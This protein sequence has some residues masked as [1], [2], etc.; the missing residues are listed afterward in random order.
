MRTHPLHLLRRAG[1]VF[2][3]SALE[4]A[5]TIEVVLIGT[6][7]MVGLPIVVSIDNVPCSYFAQAAGRGLKLRADVLKGEISRGNRLRSLLLCYF[8]TFLA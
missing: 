6:E 4:D 8:G 2:V 7:G 1:F 5:S 3:V